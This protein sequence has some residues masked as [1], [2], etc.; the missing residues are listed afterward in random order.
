MAR[1]QQLIHNSQLALI[2]HFFVEPPN[3][4]PVLLGHWDS[5][6]DA[7]IRYLWRSALASG[8]A[9]RKPGTARLQQ[10]YSPELCRAIPMGGLSIPVAHGEIRAALQLS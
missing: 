5:P 2:P 10:A 3:D 7:L 1:R 8:T 4:G 6:S 9:L